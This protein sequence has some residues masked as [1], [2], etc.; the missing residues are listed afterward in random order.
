MEIRVIE[1][2]VKELMKMLTSVLGKWSAKLSSGT[3]DEVMD[4]EQMARLSPYHSNIILKFADDTT[5]LGL[6]SNNDETTYREEGRTSR[7]GRSEPPTW[8]FQVRGSEPS[9]TKAIEVPAFATSL[10]SNYILLLHNQ[11]ASVRRLCNLCS[12]SDR[13]EEACNFHCKIA[14]C[15]IYSYFQ[16]LIINKKLCE[17]DSSFC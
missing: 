13:G 9:N 4:Q 11:N 17:W 7:K 2:D 16:Q 3:P 14:W 1:G 6:I 10:N 15:H 12:Y 5:I 8:L